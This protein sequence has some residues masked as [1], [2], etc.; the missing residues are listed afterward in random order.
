MVALEWRESMQAGSRMFLHN[1]NGGIEVERASGDQ[2]EVTV[3]KRWRRGDPDMVRVEARRTDGGR[4]ATICAFWNEDGSCDEE[5]YTSGRNR[6]RNRDN[7]VSVHYTV[8]LPDGVHLY[9]RT[10]NGA[11]SIANVTGA[12]DARTTNGA[13]KASST[14]GPVV[15][16]TVNGSIEVRMGSVGTSDLHY[17][18]VN[19]AITIE[20]PDDFAG[21]LSLRTV[22]GSLQSDFPITM[23]GRFNPR[24]IDAQVGEG[25]PRL[26]A[27]TVNGG[28]RLRK[29]Q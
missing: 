11:V 22:N 12:V 16:E 28:V 3:T 10:V 20:L 14:G 4:N 6:N 29:L 8:K 13:V 27:E 1:V 19:G 26:H 2:A 25:G 21:H 5:S 7:D 15:A 9:A 24:R 23:Q 18:T 17:E